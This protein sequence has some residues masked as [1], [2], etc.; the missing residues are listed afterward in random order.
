MS[1]HHGPD[2]PHDMGALAARALGR[3][4]VHRVWRRQFVADLGRRSFALAILGAGAVACSDDDSSGSAA[5]GTSTSSTT[6][7]AGT[8]AS[9]TLDWAQVS[10]GFVSAY[11]LVRGNEAAVVDTGNP[12]SEDEIGDALSTLGVNYGDVRHVVLTHRHPDHVGSLAGVLGEAPS[13]TAYAGAAD[14]ENISSPNPLQSVGNGDDVFGLEVIETPG[15][16]AGSISVLDT[17]IGLLIAGDA[18][19][20]NADGTEVLGPNPDF[21]DDMA[22]ANQSVAKLATRQFD[23]VVFGHGNPVR[24]SA[25]DLVVQLASE[26]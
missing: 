21:S 23:T 2:R 4:D 24:G 13:A 12:G 6:E 8:G 1:H 7:P 20:G 16:T 15:H 18:L 11:V 22:T 17:G 9:P 10:L 19:N 14:L 26:L 25:A 3:S 5:S